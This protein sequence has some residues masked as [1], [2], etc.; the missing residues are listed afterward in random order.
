MHIWHV[1]VIRNVIQYG[2]SQRIDR[3]YT[4]QG[5][6]SAVLNDHLKRQISIRMTAEHDR[7]KA[8]DEVNKVYEE[9]DEDL[10]ELQEKVEELTRANEA[11][12]YENQGLSHTTCNIRIE[13][14]LSA[15]S[16]GN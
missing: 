15:F 8:E 5:V 9:F 1:K 13:A 7:Q 3:L 11:L 12:Q 4:W 14:I 16:F 10:R 6:V 2:I